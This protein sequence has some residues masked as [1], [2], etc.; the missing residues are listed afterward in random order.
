MNPQPHALDALASAAVR[1]HAAEM[2]TDVAEHERA[3][4]NL[5]RAARAY[6]KAQQGAPAPTGGK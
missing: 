4:A 6:A 2:A 3:W 1:L 5:W